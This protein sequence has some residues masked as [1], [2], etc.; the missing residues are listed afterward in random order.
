V[1]CIYGPGPYR[2]RYRND[3]RTPRITPAGARVLQYNQVVNYN[4][5]SVVDRRGDAN[6]VSR[7]VNVPS[8]TSCECRSS[9]FGVVLVPQPH[10]RTKGGT[11]PGE[12]AGLRQSRAEGADKEADVHVRR[13]VSCYTITHSVTDG[14][15]ST[16]LCNERFPR[17]DGQGHGVILRGLTRCVTL[18][19][20]TL[21]CHVVLGVW[22][23]RPGDLSKPSAMRRAPP[24]TNRWYPP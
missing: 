19:P 2:K 16:R 6:A 10:L 17:R 8:G 3:E 11:A 21:P 13:G 15:T 9:P 23:Q 14:K 22:P 24:A 4:L 5:L 20:Q 18:Q 7:G 12:R 1:D